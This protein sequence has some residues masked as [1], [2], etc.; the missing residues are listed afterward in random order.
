MIG[1]TNVGGGGGLQSTDAILRVIAP[2]GST[3]TISKG[4]VSK[5]DQGHENAADNTLYDYYFIIHASQFDSTA[6]TVTATKGSQSIYKT[7]VINSPD[8]YD[9]TLA[10]TLWIVKNGVSQVGNFTLGAKRNSDSSATATTPPISYGSTY[11]Q[12]GWTATGTASAGIAY[13]P[14]KISLAQYKTFHVSGT[15][16]NTSQYSS[17]LTSDMWTAI[18]TYAD[19]NV[20]HYVSIVNSGTTSYTS[21]DKSINVSADTSSVYIG[22]YAYRNSSYYANVRVQNLYLEV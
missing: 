12:I 5:S 7:V 22:F 6:W 4:G 8:E 15:A 20:L 13:T 10:Y 11:I 2:A 9:V 21:F 3:V 16:I 17:N 18:G 19:N 1:R 14:N